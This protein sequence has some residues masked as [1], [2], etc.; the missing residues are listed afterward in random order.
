MLS[1]VF[2]LVR[3]AAIGAMGATHMT[4]AFRVA[5]AIPNL[6]RR[7]FG[8]GAVSIAFVP[9]FTEVGQADGRDRARQV[10]ANAAGLLAVLLGGIVVIGELGLLAWLLISPGSAEQTLL[11]KLTMIVL[12][13]MFT[14]CLLALGAAAL[15]CRKHFAY[16]AF[17]PI[18]LNIFMIAAALLAHACFDGA[19]QAGLVLLAGSVTVA[20]VLQLVGVVWLLRRMGLSARPTLR[21]VLEP[22]KRIAAL[23]LPMLLPIGILQ[24]SAFFDRLYIH[25]IAERP[26]TTT[27]EVFGLSLTRPLGE[28]VVTWFDCANRL[29]Q[30]PMG[31][32]GISLAT[33]IFPLFSRYAADNDVDGLRDT[34]NRAIRWSLFM[35]IPSGVALF[36]LA[37]P[38]VAV[39][40]RHGR[41]TSHDV[42][43]TAFML[44][45]YCL[46]MWAYFCNHILLR[47][48]FSQKDVRT[49]LWTSCILAGVNL[50][51]VVT[52]VF[53]PLA[54]GALG[55]A[56]ATTSSINAITLTFILRRRWGRLGLRNILTSLGRVI[57][58]ACV[59]GGGLAATC[60]LL[61]GPIDRATNTQAAVALLVAIPAGA[62]VFLVL[63]RLLRAPELTELRTSL[64]KK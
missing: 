6:F 57:L 40:F 32:L 35:G 58:A 31:I 50:I 45:M 3:D 34:T 41:F 38:I 23:T 18:L 20:G 43:R 44:R 24:F 26:G 60:Y 39:I 14:V 2:G 28:G 22:V 46:G 33:A 13:F 36:F 16:P 63:A 37:E 47:A 64:R 5:F 4:G 52:L 53:T 9:I 62:A 8:E 51:M 30:Y 27:L 56:T 17:A 21:P 19:S 48:F 59:M 10:L 15:N 61:L 54:G 29:Y 1:R 49:P 11:L 7:L 55:L 42:I 12:P 25:A